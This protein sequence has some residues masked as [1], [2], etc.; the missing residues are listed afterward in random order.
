MLSVLS[1]PY[2]RDTMETL[3]K[4]I[5]LSLERFAADNIS[6]VTIWQIVGDLWANSILPAHLLRPELVRAALDTM[7]NVI[8]H[9][10]GPI[11]SELLAYKLI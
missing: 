3:V 6:F 9:K 11:G 8:S 4:H 7:D 10:V 2:E 1:H 5:T